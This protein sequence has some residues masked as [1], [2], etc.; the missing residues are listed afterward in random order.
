M[1][2]TGGTISP[3]AE[4]HPSIQLVRE[5]I[6]LSLHDR[7]Y[8][9]LVSS[10]FYNFGETTTIE[11]GFP[12][13][14]AIPY[15]PEAPVFQEF[16]DF[17]T[18]V[19]DRKVQFQKLEAHEIDEAY[20]RNENWYVK[21]VQFPK[22]DYT[23]TTIKYSTSYSSSMS[24]YWA[25]YRFG[26]G[27]TWKGEIEEI[28]VV[29]RN[30]SEKWIDRIRLRFGDQSYRNQEIADRYFLDAVDQNTFRIWMSNIEPQSLGDEILIIF[31]SSD[32]P[33][34]FIRMTAE[35]SYYFDKE[36][37]SSFYLNVFTK[38]QHRIVRNIIYAWH[39]YSFRSPDLQSYFASQDWYKVNP[40][41]TESDLNQQEKEN[42]DMILEE[43]ILRGAKEVGL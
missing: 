26:T 30:E 2:A 21:E 5:R 33:L 32:T 37:I 9:V 42:R 12:E 15:Y 6:T 13:T 20:W 1:F 25:D 16:R 7:Y 29:V 22:S 34:P 18:E 8:S 14:S 41:F 35:K 38:K 28:E 23:T 24:T 27:L 17:E 43:E 10:V 3:M 40:D 36:P 39:G 19:D 4:E 31:I 11:V